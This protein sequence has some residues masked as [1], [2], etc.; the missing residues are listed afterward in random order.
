M[1]TSILTHYKKD[2]IEGKAHS[3]CGLPLNGSVLFYP[4]KSNDYLPTC[5]SCLNKHIAE[6]L[7]KN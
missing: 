7:N 6:T 4:T 2:N 5:K 1:K 3:M